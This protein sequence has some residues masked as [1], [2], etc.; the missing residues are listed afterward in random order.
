MI[1]QRALQVALILFGLL[2]LV[3][4]YPVIVWKPDLACEQMLGIVYATL[5]AFLLIAARNPSA[6][7]SLIAFTAWSSLTHGTLMAVQTYKQASP[8]RE[9]LAGVLPFFVIAIVLLALA[10]VKVPA[11]AN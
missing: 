9:Y 11:A 10:P 2:M 4:L 5:G 7:R 3:G 8:A 1:R 6:H